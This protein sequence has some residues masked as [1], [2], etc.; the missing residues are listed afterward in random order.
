MAKTYQEMFNE[1]VKREIHRQA[2]IGS[3]AKAL[4]ASSKAAVT[5]MALDVIKQQKDQAREV[6]KEQDRI[7]KEV[8]RN[9][10]SN[11]KIERAERI[12]VQ[13]ELAREEARQEATKR[14]AVQGLVTAT[15][16][17]LIGAIATSAASVSLLTRTA[18]HFSPASAIRYERA[19]GSLA[20]TVGM[21]LA[22]SF[23]KL[24]E[25][26][27]GAAKWVANLSPS[28]QKWLN[29]VVMIVAPLSAA[30]V[31][32]G[33]MATG[34][35]TITR[36]F[37][38]AA[39]AVLAYAGAL[40]VAAVS[41]GAASV[42]SNV[43]GAAGLSATVT[44]VARASGGMGALG[45]AATGLGAGGAAKG[46]GLAG[47]GVLGAGA[48]GLAGAGV[49]GYSLF[50]GQKRRDDLEAYTRNMLG[51]NKGPLSYLFGWKQSERDKRLENMYKQ[52]GAE[53]LQSANHPVQTMSSVLDAGRSFR[54]QSAQQSSLKSFDDYWNEDAAKAQAEAGKDP[55]ILPFDVI[56][57]MAT[58]IKNIGST[59]AR[60][61][62]QWGTA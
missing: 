2:T 51:V 31:L 56:N 53:A 45:T 40:R 48:L 9:K 16:Q 11:I 28:T 47:A 42:A 27:E 14:R 15:R 46:L 19:M 36:G 32:V 50:G 55:G 25:F 30:F 12:K 6:K 24:T 41:Q 18:Q 10:V 1:A 4:P 44:N 52:P 26:I 38:S 29:V 7:D 60:L 59:I 61:M 22:P 21:V 35:F 5:R 13:K 17:M 37:Y 23:Q 62:G 33:G 49:A 34:V 8:F 20:A 58:E 39:K 43:A 54:Q 3:T 57:G